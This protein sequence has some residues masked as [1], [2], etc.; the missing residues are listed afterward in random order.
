MGK[1]EKSAKGGYKWGQAGT[2]TKLTKEQ[3]NN[4]KRAAF[5]NGWKGKGG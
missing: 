2:K 3:A 4:V 1:V 5:A